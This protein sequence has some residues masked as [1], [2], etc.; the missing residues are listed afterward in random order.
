MEDTKRIL[1][2]T[3]QQLRSVVSGW[4][5]NHP[6][7]ENQSYLQHLSHAMFLSL[8]SLG[9]SATFLVHSIFP[10]LFQELGGK[11]IHKAL[12]SLIC[13]DT[14]SVPFSKRSNEALV[15]Y[16]VDSAV[17]SLEQEPL[18]NREVQG[19]M[20]SSDED[21]DNDSDEDGEKHEKNE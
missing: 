4:F 19:T 13:P 17:D 8:I 10:F 1:F 18:M 5:T 11:L 15:S 7:E 12:V 3:A 2:A 16:A 6:E 21:S 20:E 9:A 14:Q